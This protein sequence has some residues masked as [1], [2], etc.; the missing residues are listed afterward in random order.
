AKRLLAA[1][2]Q[3]VGAVA[4]DCGFS[5]AQ[6]FARAFRRSTGMTPLAFRQQRRHTISQD[7]KRMHP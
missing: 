2:D 3:A 5:H 6:S 4:R 7:H 1:P